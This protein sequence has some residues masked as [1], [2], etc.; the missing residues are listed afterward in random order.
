MPP[1]SERIMIYVK[2]ESEE[3]FT[4]KNHYNPLKSPTITQNPLKSLKFI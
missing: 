1:T 4:G 3:A 2:Q